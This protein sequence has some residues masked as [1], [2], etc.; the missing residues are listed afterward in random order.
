MKKL[1]GEAR[2]TMILD[3]LSIAEGPYP[4]FGESQEAMAQLMRKNYLPETRF[5][6]G[7]TSPLVELGGDLTL[8]ARALVRM[9][10]RTASASSLSA[11]HWRVTLRRTSPSSS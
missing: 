5:V 3:G 1:M 11:W 9:A 7:Y 6:T 2:I 8:F 10:C 4:F